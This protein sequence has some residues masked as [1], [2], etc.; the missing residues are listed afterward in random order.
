MS[1]QR[2]VTL[3]SAR[4]KLSNIAAEVYDCGNRIARY[5]PSEDVVKLQEEIRQL[6]IRLDDILFSGYPRSG[7]HWF[8]EVVNM[9]LHQNTRFEHGNLFHHLLDAMQLKNIR[10]I[11]PTLPSPRVLASHR[12]FQFLPKQAFEKKPRLVYVLRNPKDVWVS[13]FKLMTSYKSDEY[14]FFGSWE[15]Y[16][17][18]QMNGEF[19]WGSWFEHVLA[20]EEFISE[21]P[22]FSVCV[23]QFEELKERPAEVIQELCRFLK[24][25]EDKA[26][27]IADATRF[28]NMKKNVMKGGV[29]DFTRELLK[30]EEHG[31]IRK[32]NTGDWKGHF[33]VEQNERFDELFKA[34]MAGSKLG[35]K[36]EKYIK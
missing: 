9:A 16:F 6:E 4:V 31:F 20:F 25:P 33:T 5:Q 1:Q 19:L 22:E 29:G 13:F 23:I 8:F 17:E 3:Q 15:E 18:L 30:D 36:V 2:D 26:E 34:K 7:N 28:E 11:V 21:R 24:V 27:E 35:Q 32:G 12:W 14:N 10:D